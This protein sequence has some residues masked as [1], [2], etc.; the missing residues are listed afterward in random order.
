MI[1]EKYDESTRKV[2]DEMFH[3]SLWCE[4]G[5]PPL[6]SPKYRSLVGTVRCKSSRAGLQAPVLQVRYSWFVLGITIFG[7]ET[8]KVKEHSDSEAWNWTHEVW[9]YQKHSII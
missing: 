4:C 9:S 7:G 2:E 5:V 3:V 6:W 8:L 1:K